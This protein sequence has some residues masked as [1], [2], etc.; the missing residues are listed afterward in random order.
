MKKADPK[1]LIIHGP[2]LNLLGKRE[3]SVYG[4]M[5]F[6][7][8]NQTIKEKAKQLSLA[9]TTFQ[10]NSEGEIVSKINASM[11][12]TDL[13]IINPAAYTHTS[14]AI[15]DALLA[16]ELPTIE[17]HISNIFKREDFRRESLISDI[18]VGVISGL[19]THSYT[20]ALEAAKKI[21]TGT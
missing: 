2:N 17:V 21:L 1:I 6:T 18:A 11:G 15:R 8:L 9:V 16:A 7:K 19:G 12:K 13:I 14:V 20:L 5:T 3:R 4:K 10:S